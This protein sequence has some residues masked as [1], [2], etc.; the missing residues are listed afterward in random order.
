MEKKK[1]TPTAVVGKWF[2]KWVGIG[3]VVSIALVVVLTVFQGKITGLNVGPIQVSLDQNSPQAQALANNVPDVK[4][5]E[6]AQEVAK[7]SLSMSAATNNSVAANSDCPY[8]ANGFWLA[9]PY[10]YYYGANSGQYMIAY[11]PDGFAVWD[12]DAYG[13]GMGGELLFPTAQVTYN[14]WFPLIDGYFDVCASSSGMVY[15]RFTG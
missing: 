14:T 5:G 12:P 6:N 10:T 4:S 3:I 11:A 7:P 13:W 9:M 15:A 2:A 1:E 8:D